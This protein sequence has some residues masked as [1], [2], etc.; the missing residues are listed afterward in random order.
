MVNSLLR[1]AAVPVYECSTATHAGATTTTQACEIEIIPQG[2][3]AG[4]TLIDTPGVS[5]Q[6]DGQYTPDVKV[7]DMLMRR[8]GRVD[9]V[10]DPLPL[11]VC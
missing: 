5:F 11:G 9:K 8:R 3:Q 6:K 4:Y 1:K 2:A 7:R 10:K